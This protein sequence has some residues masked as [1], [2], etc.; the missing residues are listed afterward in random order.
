M[1]R[2]GSVDGSERCAGADGSV[3]VEIV[4]VGSKSEFF[5][6]GATTTTR[7]RVLPSVAHAAHIHPHIAGCLTQ[8]LHDCMLG[9]NNFG[10]RAL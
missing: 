4:A 8:A 10:N 2:D 1:E 3:R 9:L 6:G 5:F 7:D